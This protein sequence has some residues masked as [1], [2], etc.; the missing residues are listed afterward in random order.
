MLMRYFCHRNTLGIYIYIYIYIYIIR[1]SQTKINSISSTFSLYGEFQKVFVRFP[2][3]FSHTFIRNMMKQM[4]IVWIYQILVQRDFTIADIKSISKLLHIKSS[5]PERIKRIS[6]LYNL[7]NFWMK[8]L[9]DR[10]VRLFWYSSRI[11]TLTP[12]QLLLV[13]DCDRRNNSYY[14]HAFPGNEK[15][16]I[17]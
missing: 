13:C 3:N 7:E 1:I 5:F 4:E 12:Y 2:H 11:S 15:W 14:G 8:S 10:N 9:K 6:L 17:N 16:Y